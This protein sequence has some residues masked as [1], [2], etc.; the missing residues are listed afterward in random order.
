MLRQPS[1]LNRGHLGIPI[2]HPFSVEKSGWGTT[3][4]FEKSNTGQ[5]SNSGHPQGQVFL[6]PDTCEGGIVTVAPPHWERL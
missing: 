1:Q 2:H 4:T 5:V 3:K 6:I